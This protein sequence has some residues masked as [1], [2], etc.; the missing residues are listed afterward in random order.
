MIKDFKLKPFK[1]FEKAVVGGTYA[2]K[3]DHIYFVSI[4]DTDEKQDFHLINLTT[5]NIVMSS[6]SIDGVTE[7]LKMIEARAIDVN[8]VEV[9]S[10]DI[11][12]LKARNENDIYEEHGG[13]SLVRCKL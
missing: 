7:A 9:G 12:Y 4:F 6:E 5:S 1:T 3:Y 13:E 2:D 11:K 8:I 10:E